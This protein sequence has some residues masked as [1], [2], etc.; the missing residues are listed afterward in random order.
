M[1]LGADSAAHEF[2]QRLADGETQT[3][4]A[5]APRHRGISLREALKHLIQMRFGNA[6][7]AIDYAD[8]HVGCI[9]A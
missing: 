4:A 5:I 8:L 3:R 1:T 9:V 2:H 6:D 7:A